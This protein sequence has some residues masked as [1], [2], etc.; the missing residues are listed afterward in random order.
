MTPIP[1][2]ELH[3]ESESMVFTLRQRVV[4]TVPGAAFCGIARAGASA[5][6]FYYASQFWGGGGWEGAIVPALISGMIGFS[7]G[8]VAGWTCHPLMGAAIGGASSGSSCLCLFVVPAEL[9]IALSH[10]GGIDRVET[11]KAI[12]GFVAMTVAGAIA[13]GLGAAIGKYAAGPDDA[14]SR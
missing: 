5:A 6:F 14:A 1:A 2:S 12:G 4:G 3:P 10:P 8:A 11:L 9:T 13:G 7:I